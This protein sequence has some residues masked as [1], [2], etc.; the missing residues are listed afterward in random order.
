V[1][2]ACNIP[3]IASSCH[4]FD[5]LEGVV[6]RPANF[7]ELADEIDEVFSNEAYKKN[8]LD[9]AKRY[10]KDNTW[11]ASADRYIKLFYQINS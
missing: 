6:P 8:I 5:D 3:V 10:I 2:M 9:K 11:D 4:Q 1:A 7:A